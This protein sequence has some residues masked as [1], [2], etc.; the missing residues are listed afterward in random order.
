MKKTTIT[1]FAL[2]AL[3]SI[4]ASAQAAQPQVTVL[5]NTIDFSASADLIEAI[6]QEGIDVVRI[7]PQDMAQH[8]NDTMI[9]ILGGQNAPEGVGDIVGGVLDGKEK[10]ELVASPNARTVRVMPNLWAENQNVILFA[11]NEKEQ[12]RKAF[13]DTE[14][15]LLK[16][17][18]SDNATYMANYSTAT[19][20]S[21]PAAQD[22]TQLRFC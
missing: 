7:T 13:S 10:E 16:I 17:L 6:L 11:G 15:D 4:Y 18:K 12:T 21:S 9:L 1:G 20:H 22:Y 5:A 3:A 19:D 14:P 8:R 2:I